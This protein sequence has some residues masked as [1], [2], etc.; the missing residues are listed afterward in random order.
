LTRE[1]LEVLETLPRTLRDLAR[2]AIT[3]KLFKGVYD[4]KRVVEEKWLAGVAV[5]FF[6]AELIDLLLDFFTG[7]LQC[8]AAGERQR[9]N[10][11]DEPWPD[12]ATLL[13]HSKGKLEVPLPR[14]YRT[15]GF[16]GAKVGW[17]TRACRALLRKRG[18]C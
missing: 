12:A 10:L 7:P 5:S 11:M 6:G 1:G 9:F 4:K 13:S 18:G 8:Q 15:P 3:S 17:R 14:L 2:Q 16:L